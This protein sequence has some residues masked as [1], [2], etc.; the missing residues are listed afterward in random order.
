[1]SSDRT[2]I[3]RF[4]R[5]DN[6]HWLV[7][8]LTHPAGDRFGVATHGRTIMAAEANLREALAL[9]F[10]IGD[11][12]VFTLL[13][14]YSLDPEAMATATSAAVR[15]DE[16]RRTEVESIALMSL[17][18]AQLAATGLSIRDIATILGVS[19]QRVQQVLHE[20]HPTAPVFTPAAPFVVGALAYLVVNGWLELRRNRRKRVLVPAES[21]PD[22]APPSPQLAQV[23]SMV[24][25]R[26]RTDGVS[27]AEIV[28]A[29]GLS[30]AAAVAAESELAAEVG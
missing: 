10:D 25:H 19:H 3:A 6:G 30:D 14:A 22:A 11:E 23:L 1:M 12:D 20:S 21:P 29:A 4:T 18:A 15:R 9:W 24:R 13:P 26:S 5:D 7:E 2:F 17:A 27:V 16:A 28:R 8:A